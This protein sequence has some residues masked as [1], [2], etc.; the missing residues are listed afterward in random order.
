MAKDPVNKDRYVNGKLKTWKEEISTN[1]HGKIVPH[2][3]RCEVT[4]IL[5][6]SSVYQQGAN[7]YPQVYIE[8]S[9]YCAREARKH[10]LL[11]DSED[12]LL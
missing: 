3:E 1:L 4:A 2:E 5:K 11:S 12:E 8:E 6:V 10:H 7:C 9:K